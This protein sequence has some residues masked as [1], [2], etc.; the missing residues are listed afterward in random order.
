MNKKLNI[1][2]F[3]GSCEKCFAGFK[4]FDFSLERVIR[5]KYLTKVY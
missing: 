1:N 5:T 4:K 2:L 3:V